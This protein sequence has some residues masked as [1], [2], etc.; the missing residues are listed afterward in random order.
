MSNSIKKNIIEEIHSNLYIH[1]DEQQINVFLCGASDENKNSIR[2][3][4]SEKLKLVTKLN[5]VYPEWLFANLMIS[6][7]NDLL[8]LENDLANNVDIIVLPLEGLGAICELGAFASF[9][10][11]VGRILVVNS[12][13]YKRK[14]SFINDGPIRLIRRKDKKNIVYYDNDDRNQAADLIYNRLIYF[15]K[16][17][18][19][20]DVCNL[21]NLSRFIGFIV[22]ITQPTSKNELMN[23]ISQWNPS[24]PQKYFDPAIEILI[25][26]N[27]IFISKSGND[28]NLRLTEIG[29]DFYI[30]NIGR[31]LGIIRY[32][33]HLRAKALWQT[34][35]YK[36]TINIKKLEAKLLE[37]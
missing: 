32:I 9:E 15:K 23:I 35:R 7:D 18:I 4:V 5:I 36:K 16:E 28:E 13:K 33:S 30:T 2:D 26:K 31:R 6:G 1:Y 22:A 17:K 20:K 25:E 3:I 29:F 21:F 12:S 11:L 14:H 27:H 19:S 8:S 37:Q 10:E 24:V 34:N